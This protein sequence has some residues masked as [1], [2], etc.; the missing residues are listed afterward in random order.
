MP[1]QF[2]IDILLEIKASIYLAFM[3]MKS[4]MISASLIA[5]SVATP[6]PKNRQGQSGDGTAP[7]KPAAT[8]TLST[9]A[10][11]TSAIAGTSSSS[12]SGSV[13]PDLVPQ[14][15]ITANQGK[16]K[17]TCVGNNAVRIPCD[18]PPDRVQFIDKLNQ[19]V[20]AG[21]A[22]GVKTPFPEDNSKQSQIT[23]LQTSIV[24]LQ[25]FDGQ[26]GKGCPA[27]STTFVQ[28]KSALQG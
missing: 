1:F 14:F 17:G 18:C 20:Q 27:A 9:P 19:F 26:P 11:H 10:S 2:V 3:I 6:F 8:T 15:G 21:N 16:N 4:I 28:Q 23:R 7:T 13:N 24:A 12:A 5:L 25:N 22:F